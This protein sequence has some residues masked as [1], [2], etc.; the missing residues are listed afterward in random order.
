MELHARSL[1]H[2]NELLP[3]DVARMTSVAPRRCSGSRSPRVEA[4]EVFAVARGNVRLGWE[5][6]HG[7]I[8]R[9]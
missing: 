5:A 3:R 6:H 2:V 9:E 7:L 4:G 1:R 8:V